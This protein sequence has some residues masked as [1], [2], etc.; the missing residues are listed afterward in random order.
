MKKKLRE[1]A[2]DCPISVDFTAD[3][4]KVGSLGI[5]ADWGI[6]WS[7]E[8]EMLITEVESVITVKFDK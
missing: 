6:S 8:M 1:C 5:G 4:R 7:R 3:S 2:V